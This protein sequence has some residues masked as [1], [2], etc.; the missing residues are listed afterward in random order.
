MK[1]VFRTHELIV[2]DRFTEVPSKN[3]N[4][5]D[6]NVFTVFYPDGPMTQMNGGF[7]KPDIQ[8]PCT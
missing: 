3:A 1:K 2:L 5:K 6:D 8:V 4:V 7:K